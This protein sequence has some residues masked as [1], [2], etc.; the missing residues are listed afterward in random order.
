MPATGFLAHM[1][2]LK[3]CW[4]VLVA[5][6]ATSPT[7]AVPLAPV[8]LFGE[9]LPSTDDAAPYWT[10]DGRLVITEP[11][12]QPLFLT[13]AAGREALALE[14]EPRNAPLP[15]GDAPCGPEEGETFH[16]AAL[17]GDRM[18][19]VTCFQSVALFDGLGGK[20]VGERWRLGN[21]PNQVAI[22]PRDGLF[23]VKTRAGLVVV[24]KG[25]RN[26]MTAVAGLG[27]VDPGPL[28]FSPSGELLFTGSAYG[29]S[30]NAYVWRIAS[31]E[32]IPVDFSGERLDVQAAFLDENTLVARKGRRL[33]AFDSAAR[34]RLW[35]MESPCAFVD[36][37]HLSFADDAG[38]RF[39]SGSGRPCILALKSGAAATLVDVASPG[40]KL[41]TALGEAAAYQHFLA[42][43]EYPPRLS[44][45]VA[46][47]PRGT[48]ALVVDQTFQARVVDLFGKAPPRELG[49]PGRLTAAAF[50]AGGRRLALARA[51]GTVEVYEVPWAPPAA[52]GADDGRLLS[53]VDEIASFSVTRDGQKSIHAVRL[54][55]GNSAAPTDFLD[56]AALR[57]ALLRDAVVT[58]GSLAA[59]P[60]KAAP[61][62]D[63]FRTAMT[64]AEIL[65]L[66]AQRFGSELAPGQNLSSQFFV[67][68]RNDKKTLGCEISAPIL[69]FGL[70][71]RDG[72]LVEI[73]ICANEM[74]S[75]RNRYERR[76]E[77]YA[78]D[79]ATAPT[80]FVA[81]TKSKSASLP[82]PPPYI[83][84]PAPNTVLPPLSLGRTAVV[85]YERTGFSWTRHFLAARREGPSLIFPDYVKSGFVV[86]DLETMARTFV[87]APIDREARVAV[88]PDGEY[89]VWGDAKDPGLL[90]VLAMR[91]G[92]Q[93]A[94]F[95]A[96]E[97]VDA[98]GFSPDGRDVV[99]G[100]KLAVGDKACGVL[101]FER[102]GGEPACLLADQAV[103][104]FVFWAQV[105]RDGRELFIADQGGRRLDVF[106]V[107][108]QNL[109]RQTTLAEPDIAM[110]K[111]RSRPA[112]SASGRLLVAATA[113]GFCALDAV[114]FHKVG[115]AA[116]GSAVLCPDE[117]CF[118]EAEPTLDE[119]K[120]GFYRIPLGVPPQVPDLHFVGP[121]NAWEM[122]GAFA[123]PPIF[124][125]RPSFENLIGVFTLP[126]RAL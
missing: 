80:L 73:G 15:R 72:S 5:V 13:Y 69:R 79:A 123:D 95:K 103:N 10:K 67:F 42:E 65:A 11:G 24:G 68:G 91:S 71:K 25:D 44:L 122:V 40:I 31:G 61:V 22:G 34:K 64:G 121:S 20:Q 49:A 23:A 2:T 53:I 60:K 92:V 66:V 63:A 88:S 6:L 46:I 126:P 102:S 36:V 120:R 76:R 70:T 27:G 48:V 1:S 124:V 105:S 115:C 125:A 59:I 81:P 110:E 62:P 12:R 3:R 93:R 96:G 94:P 7:L 16:I 41:D 35:G 101:R 82:I 84:K 30:T 47:A 98:L 55:D 107:A 32:L 116:H 75:L 118:L 117:Q 45:R 99:V 114:D 83:W 18:V 58:A 108:T 77:R 113:Q 33:F 9:I 74:A 39:A 86:L 57:Q 37:F 89:A 4:I 8:L 50:D 85:R 21:E 104:G 29:T 17:P 100:G 26:G 78:K 112:L 97:R 43:Q 111:Y 14:K 87:P 106:D 52:S 109:L 28:V 56:D 54:S 51:D 90:R 19:L 119:A 38:L